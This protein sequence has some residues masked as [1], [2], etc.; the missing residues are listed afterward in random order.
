MN[1]LNTKIYTRKANE[2]TWINPNTPILIGD[3]QVY[4]GVIC[5]PAHSESK[6]FIVGESYYL[7]V[8]NNFKRVRKSDPVYPALHLLLNVTNF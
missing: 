6:Q 4:K 5:A 1:I 2:K 7:K 3:Y 8:K